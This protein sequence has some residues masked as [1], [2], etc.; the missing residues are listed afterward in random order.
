M[1]LMNLHL[2]HQNVWFCE[3]YLMSKQ[4][5]LGQS[6][7]LFISSPIGPSPS[8]IKTE[9]RSEKKNTALP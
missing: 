7:N 2:T 5:P 9:D 4:I 6:L 1:F 3:N 8:L